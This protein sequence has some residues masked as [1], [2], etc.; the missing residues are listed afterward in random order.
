MKGTKQGVT[1]L[2]G[3]VPPAQGVS[4][5]DDRDG[6][7]A[8]LSAASSVIDEIVRDGALRMLAEALLVESDAYIAASTPT[9][10]RTRRL[11][12]I[13]GPE[14]P[15]SHETYEF[16]RTPKARSYMMT[17]ARQQGCQSRLL[18][19]HLGISMQVDVAYMST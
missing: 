19:E 11:P 15:M 8:I 13:R 9:I 6:S 12:P 16:W 3:K 17:E 5:S 4:D 14:T 10:T 2:A 1:T 7:A 18:T